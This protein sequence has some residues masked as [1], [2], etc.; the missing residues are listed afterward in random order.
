[1]K[2]RS[3]LLVMDLT[4]GRALAA[5]AGRGYRP[6]VHLYETH[7]M[8]SVSHNPSLQFSSPE[9]PADFGRVLPG[10]VLA[11]AGRCPR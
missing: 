8:R 7:Q 3:A 2:R 4:T 9:A 1:M 10:Y 5:A 11:L 6:M